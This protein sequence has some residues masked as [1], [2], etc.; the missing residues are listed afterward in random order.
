M[1]Q[2]LYYGPP[3]P[4]Q[5]V[6]RGGALNVALALAVVA[7]LALVG[8][9]VLGWLLEPEG[10][11]ADSQDLGTTEAPLAA[12]EPPPAP[13]PYCDPVPDGVGGIISAGMRDPSMYV[14]PYAVVDSTYFD[15]PLYLVAAHILRADG[16]REISAEAWALTSLRPDAE[17]IALSNGAVRLTV[18]PDGDTVLT[19]DPR[20]ALPDGRG[21]TI[22]C[23]RPR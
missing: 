14:E 5:P 16:S 9:A 11:A 13:P 12:V 22:E 6:K 19:S 20:D 4:P 18:W 21:F 17:V 3:Q 8:L 15:P 10:G 23:A 2:Q 1:G 7:V